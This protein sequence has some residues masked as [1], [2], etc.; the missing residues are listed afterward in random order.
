MKYSGTNKSDVI[1]GTNSADRFQSLGG[2]RD[3]IFARGG[4]DSVGEDMF[5]GAPTSD[6]VYHLGRGNDLVRTYEGNDV[7][8]GGAGKD[9]ITAYNF[10]DFVVYGGR[11]HDVVEIE[12]YFNTYTIEQLSEHTAIVRSNE[13]DQTIYLHDVEEIKLRQNSVEH[14]FDF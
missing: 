10:D 13:T 4:N 14:G 11:G 8:S 1:I 6:D 5:A 7:V 2:G 3:V 9:V 12:N